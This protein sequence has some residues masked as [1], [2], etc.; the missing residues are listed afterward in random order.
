MDWTARFPPRLERYGKLRSISLTGLSLVRPPSEL[1]LVAVSPAVT[2]SDRSSEHTR[3]S[4]AV[5]GNLC[6]VRSPLMLPSWARGEPY[7]AKA[8]RCWLFCG[9]VG[10][11]GN[12]SSAFDLVDDDEYRIER[13][14]AFAVDEELRVSFGAVHALR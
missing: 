5:P 3:P 9:P 7:P 4:V 10:Q 6:E 12:R 11:P 14:A 13:D 8:R 2:S 1:E